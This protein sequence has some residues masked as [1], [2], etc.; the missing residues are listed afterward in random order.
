MAMVD[1]DGVGRVEVG[2][3]LS[4]GHTKVSDSCEPHCLIMSLLICTSLPPFGQ[5]K[6]DISFTSF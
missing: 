4:K 2:A 5:Y 3:N 1:V 6:Y